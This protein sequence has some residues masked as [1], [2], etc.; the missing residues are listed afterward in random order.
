M[1]GG[2]HRHFDRSLRSDG[3]D[4]Y[5]EY[6][7]KGYHV[8]RHKDDLQAQEARSGKM[9]GTFSNDHQPYTLDHVNTPELQQSVPTLAE[10]AELSIGNLS[11]NSNGFI[12]QVEGGRID[13]AAHSNDIG[14]LIFDQ[15]A[16]DDAIGVVLDFAMNR[17]DTLVIITTDH[18][19]ANPGFNSSPD[20]NF[21]QIADF[22]HTNDWIRRE[23]NENSSISQVRERIEAATGL[24]VSRD[25]AQAYLDSVKGTYTTI[26]NRLPSR[27]ADMVQLL[28]NPTAPNSTG[29]PH[30]PD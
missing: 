30:P 8:A 20:R 13:H 3:R 18:G 10:L 17:D 4:L 19:N 26:Y 12:L 5:A 11:Q 29:A 1:R 6:A 7:S 28:P 22:T 27:S 21:D 25:A 15:I 23:L 9:V 24:E 2:G 16:F 14:G